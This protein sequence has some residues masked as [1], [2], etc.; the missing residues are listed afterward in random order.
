MGR[1]EPTPRRRSLGAALGAEPR[2]QRRTGRRLKQQPNAGAD[3]V[4]G[5][6]DQ[7]KTAAAAVPW[8]RRRLGSARTVGP[9]GSERGGG[10][11]R[12]FSTRRRPGRIGSVV[13]GVSA[14]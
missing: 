14:Q 2:P 12:F 5:R 7:V 3:T 6:L 11:A 1:A 8:G 4:G 13:G 10:D 9:S